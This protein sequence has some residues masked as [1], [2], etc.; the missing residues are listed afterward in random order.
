MA[1]CSDTFSPLVHIK[2]VE[3]YSLHYMVFNLKS[4]VTFTLM[5]PYI[6]HEILPSHFPR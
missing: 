1:E 6:N 3:L 4:N 5:L 2:N